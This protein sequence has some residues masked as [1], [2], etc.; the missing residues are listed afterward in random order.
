MKYVFSSFLIF[1]ALFYILCSTAICNEK[2][3]FYS[4][5]KVKRKFTPQK[6]PSII[7]KP[8]LLEVCPGYEIDASKNIRF[9]ANE[10]KLICGDAEAKSW[11]KI[12]VFEAKYFIKVFL[13]DRGYYYPSFSKQG[14]TIIIYPGN[15]TYIKKVEVIGNPPRFFNINKRWKTTGSALTPNELDNL[16]DWSE[17]QLKNNGYPCPEAQT[18][19]NAKTGIVQVHIEPGNL[20]RISEITEEPVPGLRKG[21]LKRYRAFDIGNIYDAKKLQLTSNRIE[22][23]YGILQSSYFLTKCTPNGASLTQKSITGP[24]RLI[25]IGVGASTEDYIIGKLLWKWVRLGKNGSSLQMFLRGSYREQRLKFEGD[26]YPLPF[27]TSWHLIPSITTSRH[28]EKRF[29]YTSSALNLPAAYY[30]DTNNLHI[31]LSFGPSFNHEYT[32]RGAQKGHT[33]FVSNIIKFK[34]TSHDF[35]YYL[36]EPHQGFYIKTKINLNHDKL[37]SKVTAQKIE[38]ESQTLFNIGKYDHPLF[39]LALRGLIGS[40]ITNTQA[41][42]FGKLPPNFFYY[43]GGSETLRGFERKELPNA[44][45]GALTALYAGAEI[46]LAN[47]FPLNIQP[48][49]F[50]DFAALGD[51]SIDLDFPIYWSPGFGLRWPSLIGVFRLTFGHG[52]L[53]QNDN[54]SNNSLKHWQVYLSYGE[55]F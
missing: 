48:L 23:L 10:K 42:N 51:K 13:Q 22:N 15:K 32:V 30:T 17:L 52:L 35:E 14:S 24:R 43:L 9:N 20:N 25:N 26:I 47:Y 49:A 8:R 28:N 34:I 55:E 3:S 12:P 19:A 36:N 7:S 27:P 53:I 39:V 4:C 2:P 50:V 29:E 18:R 11:S 1:A 46:R 38:V 16:E 40:T 6:C 54:A 5:P 44:T 31:D 33:F 21:T 45:R 41:T 37:G